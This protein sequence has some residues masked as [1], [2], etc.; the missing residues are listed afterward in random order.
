MALYS[1]CIQCVHEICLPACLLR[2]HK[3]FY[4]GGVDTVFILS[5]LGGI[6]MGQEYNH[7]QRIPPPEH[8]VLMLAL[9][10]VFRYLHL[11]TS[12]KGHILTYAPT[13]CVVVRVP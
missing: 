9:D 8:P 11:E 3:G 10:N 2:R 13:L 12:L 6:K 7:Y 1:M 5:H 4:F